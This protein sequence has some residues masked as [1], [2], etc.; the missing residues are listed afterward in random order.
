[1][2]S[3]MPSI[4]PA[5][6]MLRES[7]RAA[8]AIS[9]AVLGVLA[10]VVGCRQDMQDQPKFVPQRGPTSLPWPFRPASG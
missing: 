8:K 2:K 5:E 6:P 4:Y 9:L 3:K 7:R 10:L 1:M